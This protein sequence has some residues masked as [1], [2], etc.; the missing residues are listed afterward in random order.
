[1]KFYS[2]TETDLVQKDGVTT[3]DLKKIK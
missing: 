2:L 1:L 3:I